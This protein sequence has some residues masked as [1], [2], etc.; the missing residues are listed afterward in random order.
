DTLARC[1]PLSDAIP[2]APVR[3]E[4]AGSLQYQLQ[5]AAMLGLDNVGLPISSD[6]IEALFGV[7]KQHGVGERKDAKRLALRLPAFCGPPPREEAPQVLAV[8]VAEQQETTGRCSSVTKQRREVLP[9]P[10]ALESVGEAQAHP[11]VELIP[12]AKN[13]SNDQKTIYVSNSYKEAWGPELHQPARHRRPAS[14]V[15]Q[16]KRERVSA[17]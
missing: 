10:H 12:R 14:A 16:G 17:S 6:P 15:S 11:H 5:T 2:S 8:S 13:R 7:A 3:R 1:E 4:F 9:N